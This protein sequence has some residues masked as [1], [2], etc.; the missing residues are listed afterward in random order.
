MIEQD[1]EDPIAEKL[2]LNPGK[3]GSWM[4]TVEGDK[5]LFV[6]QGVV[7]KDAKNNFAVAT[8]QNGEIKTK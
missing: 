7:T 6:D 1:L 3:G 4:V 2:L 8:P 5:F